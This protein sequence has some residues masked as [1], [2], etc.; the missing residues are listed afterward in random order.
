MNLDNQHAVV[1]SFWISGKLQM[2]QPERI[3]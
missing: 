1:P 3:W 2:E